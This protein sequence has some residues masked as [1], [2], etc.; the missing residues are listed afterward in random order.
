MAGCAK[1]EIGEMKALVTPKQTSLTP[2]K[3][4]DLFFT[5]IAFYY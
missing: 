3:V 1:K 4:S 5:F 2:L